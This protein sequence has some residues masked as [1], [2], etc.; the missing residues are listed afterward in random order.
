MTE[1]P[2]SWPVITLLPV[3]FGLKNIINYSIFFSRNYQ[4]FTREISIEKVTKAVRLG[5]RP[6]VKNPRTTIPAPK[7]AAVKQ[8]KQAS[9]THGDFNEDK[10]TGH[11]ILQLDLL[12][13]SGSQRKSQQ[14]QANIAY[15]NGNIMRF[16][17]QGKKLWQCYCSKAPSGHSFRSIDGYRI[18]A[19]EYEYV[20]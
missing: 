18:H 3:K 6:L 5:K 10:D 1:P 8:A 11:V 7:P 13:F 17:D 2:S 12:N 19:K 14:M 20:A 4:R 9:Q 15:L 16:R